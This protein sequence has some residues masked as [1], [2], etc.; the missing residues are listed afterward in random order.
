MTNFDIQVEIDAPRSSVWA[1]LVDVAQWPQWTPTV[2]RVQR[3]E[4]GPLALGSRTRIKQPKLLPAIW[5]VTELDENA[6]LFTW[7]AHSPGVVITARH[8]LKDAPAGTLATFSLR[9]SGLAAPLVS[10]LLDGLSRQYVATEAYSLKA[11]SEN[12][13]SIRTANSPSN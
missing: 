9:I 10:L 12:S 5:Q 2:T 8:L 13:P 11:L 4:A 6:G 3:L 7:A 1:V